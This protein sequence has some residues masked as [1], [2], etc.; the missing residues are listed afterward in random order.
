MDFGFVDFTQLK[1]RRFFCEQEVR[2]N[3]RLT[4]GIYLSVVAFSLEN[5]K[6]TMGGSGVAVEYAVQMRQLAASRTM[7]HLI[8]ANA[9]SPLNLER[10]AAIMAEFHKRTDRVDDPDIWSRINTAC[11]ENFRH[12]QPYRGKLLDSGCLDEIQSATGSLLNRARNLFDRRTDAG[13]IRD[14]HGDLRA[15]HVYFTKDGKIQILDCI[16]FNDRLRMVDVASDLAFL[17]MDLDY[18]GRSQLAAIFLEAY[19]RISGDASLLS[20]M[21]FYKCYRA[22]V[23]CKVSC[24]QLSKPGIDNEE[25]DANCASACRFLKLAHRYARRMIEPT[26]WIFCGLPASGKSTLSFRLAETLGIDCF[27][28]DRVRKKLFGMAPLDCASGPLDQGL[29]SGQVSQ[30]VYDQLLN[31]AR[32]KMQTGHSVILDA[33]YGSACHRE[34]AFRLA[35]EC[36][37]QIYFVE[38][39]AEDTVIRHRLRQREHTASVSDARLT[40]FEALRSRFEPLNDIPSSR[41][42]CIDSTS[43]PENCLNSLFIERYLYRM[44][45]VII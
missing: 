37:A 44:G 35:D 28:S 2:L 21:D 8:K 22:M 30:K 25:R 33:T 16:E 42:I 17:A 18:L 23:R 31:M 32:E 14:G 7:A 29:Y 1:K 6:I 41:H 19:C 34:K 43:S 13:K 24:I 4:R 10:L 15:E 27:N 11:D 45:N 12:V 36:I 40:Q 3:R 5:N 9:L 38:C 26:L 20:L 39:I